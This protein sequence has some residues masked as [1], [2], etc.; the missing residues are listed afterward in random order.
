[1]CHLSMKFSDTS[2]QNPPCTF[3]KIR[4]T[5]SNKKCSHSLTLRTEVKLEVKLYQYCVVGENVRAVHIIKH[6][7][8]I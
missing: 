3:N 8:F 5:L 2:N 1:M 7:L 4:E 6:T